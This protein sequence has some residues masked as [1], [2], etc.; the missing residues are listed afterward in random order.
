MGGTIHVQPMEVQACALIAEL[1]VDIDHNNVSHSSSDLRNWPLAVDSD[2]RTLES[3]IRICY[4][5]SDIEV[6]GKGSATDVKAK[7]KNE[8]K[9]SREQ[10]RL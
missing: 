2:G 8:D 9:I 7:V 5:P 10:I 3:A 4:D 6:I 1:I